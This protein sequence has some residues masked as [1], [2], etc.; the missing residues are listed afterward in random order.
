MGQKVQIL[1]DV[2]NCG[3]YDDSDNDDHDDDMKRS[4]R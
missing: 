2:D 3:G 1:D 4:G